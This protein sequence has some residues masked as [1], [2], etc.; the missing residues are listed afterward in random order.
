MTPG[1]G[2]Y[3]FRHHLAIAFASALYG[4]ITV[5]GRYFA[6][7]GYSLL[8]I[9]L[10]G[11]VF[12]ALVL[13]PWVVFVPTHRPRAADLALFVWFGAAGAG[14]QLAQFAGIVLGVPVAMV[15]L[16][17]YSQPI[18]T[19]ILG[20]IWLQEPVTRAKLSALG[21]ASTGT[22]V[23]LQ[24][25]SD[26]PRYPVP[27]LLA[28]LLGGVLLSLWVMFSRVSGLRGNAP[29]TTAFGY[30]AGTTLWLLALTP[31]LRIVLP[32]PLLTRLDPTVWADQWLAV[33]VYTLAGN[34]LPALLVMWGLR[35]IHASTAGVLL[36]FEPVSAA[37]L[38]YALF[39]EPLTG[40]IGLGG[41]LI[42]V[43]NYVLVRGEGRTGSHERG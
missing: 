39:A 34:L 24:P 41:A 16:L 31:A 22:V 10:T 17:L 40:P 37:L 29:L 35:R 38:A 23:L 3:D 36:L 18:W 8:E 14:L 28:A 5:G 4:T 9:S 1:A 26:A 20:R 30:S 21:L 11:V 43:S 13:L 25:F 7:S 42:L 19:V 6:D 32:Q 12:T 15:A 27:G 2:G 33:A